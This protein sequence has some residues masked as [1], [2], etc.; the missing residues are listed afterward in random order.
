M[1]QQ[2]KQQL[3]GM[4]DED[5]LQQMRQA[6]EQQDDWIQFGKALRNYEGPRTLLYHT[7]RRFVPGGNAHFAPL[8]QLSA[9]QERWSS[10]SIVDGIPE[11]LEKLLKRFGMHVSDRIASSINMSEYRPV[12]PRPFPTSLR[13]AGMNQLRKRTWETFS[14]LAKRAE[15]EEMTQNT[16]GSVRNPR[17]Q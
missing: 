13:L 9:Q 4:P 2:H 8:W 11:G 10:V 16:I 15:R 6:R 3:L 1:V 14:T 7:L 12:S 5:I 17:F